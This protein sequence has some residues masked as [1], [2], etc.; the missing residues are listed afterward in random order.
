MGSTD[1][2]AQSSTGGL[3]CEH[4]AGATVTGYG[5]FQMEKYQIASPST[6]RA[7]QSIKNGFDSLMLCRKLVLTGLT[8]ISNEECPGGFTKVYYLTC[9]EKGKGVSGYIPARIR[10]AA[11]L[12]GV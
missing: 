3:I 10:G 11:T 2:K 6:D 4:C 5:I 7:P 8:A 9:G 12:L 1:G